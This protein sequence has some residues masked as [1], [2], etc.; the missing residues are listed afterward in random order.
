M[1]EENVMDD[2]KAIDLILITAID[3]L[4]FIGTQ[5]EAKPYPPE[6]YNNLNQA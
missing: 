5:L 3:L 2:A 4:Q 6:T 1:V